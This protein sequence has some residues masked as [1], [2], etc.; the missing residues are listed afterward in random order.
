MGWCAR[1]KGTGMWRE[2][3]LDHFVSSSSFFF[4]FGTSQLCA[5]DFISYFGSVSEESCCV[6]HDP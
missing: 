2:A 1:A 6:R 3:V 5:S 4:I